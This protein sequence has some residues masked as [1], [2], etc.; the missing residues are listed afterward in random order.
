MS[1]MLPERAPITLVGGFRRET[2]AGAVLPLAEVL[3]VPLVDV[4]ESNIPVKEAIEEEGV[5]DGVEARKRK[6]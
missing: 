5:I 1:L 6:C 3:I 4:A 2:G